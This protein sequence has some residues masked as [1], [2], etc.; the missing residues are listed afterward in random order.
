MVDLFTEL[1]WVSDKRKE[2]QAAEKKK[3]EKKEEIPGR[4]KNK[5]KALKVGMSR[6]LSKD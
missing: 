5:Q 4:G 2:E 6:T 3:K 1:S